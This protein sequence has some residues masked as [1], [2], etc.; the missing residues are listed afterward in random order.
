MEVEDPPTPTTNHTILHSVKKRATLFDVLGIALIVP[1]ILMLTYSLTSAN[2]VGWGT[3]QILGILVASLLLLGLFV[4]REL[5]ATSPLVKPHLFRDASFNFTLVLAVNTYAVRQACTY[6]LTLQLQ[7]YGNSPLHT[8]VLF[9]PL[10]VSALIANNSAG[11]LIPIFG[12]KAMFIAGW[13]LAI[14]GTLLFSFISESSSYWR[15]TFP[16][17]IL[18]IAG[19][20]AVYITTNFIV[21]SSVA[22]ADQGVAAGVFNVA[23]QVGGSVLGLAIL[24]AV[25]QGIDKQY[26]SRSGNGVLSELG[27]RSVYYSCVILCGIGLLLSLFVV[28]VPE[29]LSGRLW[30]KRAHVDDEGTA[31]DTANK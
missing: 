26:G 3:G 22:K 18:Y 30:K 20:G 31:A 2:V 29:N 28:R 15:F 5:Y 19:I 16:G 7:S 24:T 27:Y 23:L 1:G 6:F 9:I 21:V 14:P 4:V 8:A 11:R 17:M 25:A 10:G 13:A 12:A